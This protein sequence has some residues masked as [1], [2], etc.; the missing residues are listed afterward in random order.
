LFYALNKDGQRIKPFLRGKGFCPLCNAPVKAYCGEIYEWHWKHKTKNSCDQWFEVETK[1]HR[2]WK[3]KFSSELQEVTVINSNGERHFADIK[4]NNGLVIELQNSPISPRIIRQRE[5]FYKKMIWILNANKFIGNFKIRSVVNSRLRDLDNQLENEKYNKI[6]SIEVNIQNLKQQIIQLHQQRFLLMDKL[7]LL[8]EKQNTFSNINVAPSLFVKRMIE[9]WRDKNRFYEKYISELLYEIEEKYKNRV[10]Q[11]VKDLNELDKNILNTENE[12]QMFEKF[13]D[14][15]IRDVNFKILPF[16]NNYKYDITDL[17]VAKQKTLETLLPEIEDIRSLEDLKKYKF[18][19]MDYVILLDISERLVDYK[20]KLEILKKKKM[21]TY[22][23]LLQYKKEI[24][25]LVLSWIE[26]NITTVDESISTIK[27]EIANLDTKITECSN[28]KDSLMD[29]QNIEIKKIEENINRKRPRQR[30]SIMFESKGLYS[31]RW[32]HKRKS[33]NAAL[34]PIYFDLG[35][36]FLFLLVNDFI[37]QK[38]KLKDF[39]TDLSTN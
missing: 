39:L 26:V 35:K 30:T 15:L 2:D 3:N 18:K 1:W 19:E 6:R 31:F 8:Q 24:T 37:L 34:K 23:E 17:K 14:Y 36:D 20:Y 4:L 10:I 5:N 12:I 29:N 28:D 25:S 33:W 21:T 16:V 22:D 38:I 32:K 7:Y 11:I 13:P 27:I 9:H